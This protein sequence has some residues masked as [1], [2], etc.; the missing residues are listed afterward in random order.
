MGH[1]FLKVQRR[2]PHL[3]GYVLGFLFI[4]TNA[5]MISGTPIQIQTF[6]VETNS[7]VLCREGVCVSENENKCPVD[8]FHDDCSDNEDF[9]QLNTHRGKWMSLFC[10]KTC[11]CLAN[12]NDADCCEDD[13]GSST[14][15]AVASSAALTTT[16]TGIQKEG[17]SG[18]SDQDQ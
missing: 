5:W 13:D 11:H 14:E 4:L 7:T 18:S 3:S 15:I 6:L 12:K 2:M 10:K 1:F 16:D 17:S 9:C 8:F